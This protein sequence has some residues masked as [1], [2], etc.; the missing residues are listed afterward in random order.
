M[1]LDKNDCTLIP[2]IDGDIYKIRIFHKLMEKEI[3]ELDQKDGVD[4]K[5]IKNSN[6]N[7]YEF[8]ADENDLPKK[9]RYSIII[10]LFSIVETQGEELCKEIRDYIPDTILSISDIKGSRIERMKK[11]LDLVCDVYK[12]DNQL[13]NSLV[14]L[15]KLR[16]IIVH[17]YGTIDD[18]KEKKYFQQISKQ[19]NQIIFDN[20][21]YLHLSKTFCEKIINDV[22]LWFID[23]FTCA[24]LSYE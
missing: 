5:I 14:L 1:N 21:Q 12:S 16:N 18:E 10:F 13:W 6:Y 8:S 20:G 23:V 15:E 24:G 3:S 22:E 7:D 9:L 17:N 2:I 4:C 19:T 11:Y